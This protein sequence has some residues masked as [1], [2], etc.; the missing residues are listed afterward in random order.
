MFMQNHTR[1]KQLLCLLTFSGIFIQTFSQNVGIGTTTPAVSGKLHV[2]DGGSE[3]SI[4]LTNGF[5]TAGNGRGAR[6]R[7]VGSDVSIINNET[8]GKL[9]MVTGAITR[10]L[11]DEEG[12]VGIGT[13]SLSQRGLHVHDYL[14]GSDVSIRLTNAW[15]TDAVLRGVRMRFFDNNFMIMNYEAGGT[16][17]LGTSFATRLLVD[18]SGRI[19]INNLSPLHKLD[20]IQ[21]DNAN[22]IRLSHTGTGTYGIYTSMPNAGNTGVYSYT[23]TNA[24]GGVRAVAIHGISG[25]GGIELI[26][27]RNFAVI[28]E[29]RNALSGVGVFGISTAPSSSIIDASVVGINFGIGTD[30]YGIIGSSF[31]SSGAGVVGKT[32]NATSGVYGI[33]RNATGPAIKAQ[34]EGSAVVALELQNGALK[35]SGTNKTVFRIVGQTGVNISSNQ[36]IIPNTTLANNQTDLLI[37]TPVYNTATGIYLNKPIG[38]W[39]NGSNWTIFTQDSSPMPNNIEFN[40]LVVK[41]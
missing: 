36:V 13:S 11:I 30:S 2:H 15:S 3:T 18:A 41:Q 25:D 31:G 4:L 27:N 20:I 39:W 38:V 29:N 6:F 1:M 28:G 24:S 17:E 40:V 34:T 7:M 21:N 33:A 32:E 16:V 35:V 37:V 5:T 9:G 19:G 10:L 26:P 8:N 12:R 22:G 23:P 14:L